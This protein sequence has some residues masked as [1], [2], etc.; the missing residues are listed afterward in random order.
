MATSKFTKECNGVTIN[1]GA[2]LW[3]NERESSAMRCT[4]LI[5]VLYADRNS[6]Q[7][8]I[9]WIEKE[10]TV[11]FRS[12]MELVRLTQEALEKSENW[13]DNFRTWG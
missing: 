2:N 11:P 4:F 9:Q 13:I 6:I 7:G 1:E 8:Y 12:Y 10:R 5:K 3:G